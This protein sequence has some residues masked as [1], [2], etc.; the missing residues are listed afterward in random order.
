LYDE[1][2]DL[3]GGEGSYCGMLVSVYLPDFTVHCGMLVSAYLPDFTVH[4]SMLVSVYLPD[5]MVHCGM[6]VSAYLPD[7][8]VSILLYAGVCMPIRLHGLKMK[9]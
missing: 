1:T 9:T 5:F 6:L 3:H 8:T 2:E 7:S 4:C